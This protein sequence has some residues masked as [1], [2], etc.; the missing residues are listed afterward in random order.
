MHAVVRDCLEG[1]RRNE[2]LASQALVEHLYPLVIRIVRSHLPR[3]TAEE[4]L[5][6]EVYLKIFTRLEQYRERDGVPFEHW[7]S[8]LAVRTCLDQLRAERRRPEWRWSDLNEEEA[9]WLD[10]MLSTPIPTDPDVKRP[11]AVREGDYGG[12]VLPE[13]KLSADQL[14]G[15]GAQV[16]SVG[17]LWLRGLVPL[18]GGELPPND[19]LQLVT[20]S[21]DE[22]SA[23]VPCCALGMRKN[24]NGSLELL[25]YGKNKEPLLKV[26]VKTIQGTQENPVEM[27]AE[28]WDDGGWI[29]LRILGKYEASFMVTDPELY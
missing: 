10:S 20:V 24:N 16:V 11:V 18:C 5:V 25:V 4:D 3:R 13:A 2:P 28:R 22:G 9:G 26:P 8:R 21:T 29:T 23:S 12:M 14:S 15:E 27:Q 19:Q 6:Q 1:V 17:Q 7:V